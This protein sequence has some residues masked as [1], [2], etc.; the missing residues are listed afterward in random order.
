MLLTSCLGLQATI[1]VD[2]AQLFLPFQTNNFLDNRCG[3]FVWVTNKVQL[4]LGGLISNEN[5][6]LILESL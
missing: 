3:F 1:V 6:N 4:L 5:I 2:E